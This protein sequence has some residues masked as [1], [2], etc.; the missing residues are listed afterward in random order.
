MTSHSWARLGAPAAAVLLAL[1]IIFGLILANAALPMALLVGWL[2][3]SVACLGIGAWRRPDI[4]IA[5]GLTALG[6]A[7]VAALIWLN[8]L[9]WW[10]P[11][12][13][14][15]LGVAYVA[16]AGLLPGQMAAGWRVSL[17]SSGIF[18][19]GIGAA[20]EIGQLVIADILASQGIP[21][22]TEDTNALRGSFVLSSL[23]LVGGSLLWVLSH[24]RLQALALTALLLAQL[25]VALVITAT[26]IGDP[27]AAGLFAL[28]LLVV[29]LAS[30][31]G[32]YALRFWLPEL[33]PENA[34]NPWRF[35]RQRRWRARVAQALKSLPKPDA[36]WLCFLLDGLALL[37]IV[38]A[39]ALLLEQLAAGPPGGTLIIVL[40][41]GALLSVAVAYWQQAPWLVLLA[42]LFLIGGIYALGLL[43]PDPPATWPL[44]YFAATAGML[45]LAIWLRSY[46]QRA[47]AFPSLL[48]AL[49]CAALALSLALERQSLGWMLGMVLAL[50]VVAVLAFWGW[51]MALGLSQR[52]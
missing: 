20:W 1:A 21:L 19:A 32:T 15:T 39:A 34:P 40:I 45:G 5:P 26:Q 52:L 46:S 25:A 49:G 36:W 10:W 37:L 41:A 6:G 31:V 14:V 2:V 27:G 4:W 12:G 22:L 51:R 3:S 50:A 18:I 30:H 23:L 33:A 28:S 17:E 43:A 7:A 38:V 16:L 24:R 13:L 11:L 48:A 35:L 8:V 42:G 47:W 44:L 9:N 29:A